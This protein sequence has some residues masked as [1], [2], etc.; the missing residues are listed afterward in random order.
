MWAPGTY[1]YTSLDTLNSLSEPCP[2]LQPRLWK[3]FWKNP[4]KSFF[5]LSKFLIS[6][7][8][9]LCRR[10]TPKMGARWHYRRPIKN[11]TALYNSQFCVSLNFSLNWPNWANS[12]IESPCPSICV[13]VVLRQRVPGEQRRSQGI[14]AVSQCFWGLSLVLRSHDLFQASH[15]PSPQSCPPRPLPSPLIFFITPSTIFEKF[16]FGT[17]PKK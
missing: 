13:C 7:T 15:C 10:S 8:G 2:E 16:I 3:W 17:H 5:F 6:S 11:L 4:T 9:L 12:V 14:K 1:N